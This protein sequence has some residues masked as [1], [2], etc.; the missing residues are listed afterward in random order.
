MSQVRAILDATNGAGTA[1]QFRRWGAGAHDCTGD[2]MLSAVDSCWCQ[3]F[4]D[5]FLPSE[6]KPVCLSS[7][8]VCVPRT[9]S[10]HHT[11]RSYLLSML[12][13]GALCLRTIS[14]QFFLVQQQ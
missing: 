5:C 3:D 12:L 2:T 6:Q 1:E 7:L 4:V 14:T 8:I 11:N 10:Y 9:I 13:H